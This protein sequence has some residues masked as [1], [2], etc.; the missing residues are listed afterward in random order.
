ML[1]RGV[2]KEC[3]LPLVKGFFY[4]IFVKSTDK[5]LNYLMFGQTLIEA[6]ME[7]L[8]SHEFHPW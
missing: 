3:K 2:Y 5:Q 1:L 7:M 8:K 6:K 4:V